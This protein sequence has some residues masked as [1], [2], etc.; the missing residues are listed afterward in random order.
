[1]KEGGLCQTQIL[2]STALDH[3]R[4]LQGELNFFELCLTVLMSNRFVALG[5]KHSFIVSAAVG[6]AY[7]VHQP[8]S[9]RL[10][11]PLS[12]F[13]RAAGD[14]PQEKWDQLAAACE[15]GGFRAPMITGFPRGAPSR[16][17]PGGQSRKNDVMQK[18]FDENFTLRSRLLSFIARHLF[19]Y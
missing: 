15:E 7:P 12:L 5:V 16:S 9:N 17:V 8:R 2:R 13:V 11:E 6:E 3:P 10:V 4:D 19:D 14:C 18:F 1:M